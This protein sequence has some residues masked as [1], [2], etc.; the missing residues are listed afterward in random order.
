MSEFLSHSDKKDIIKRIIT[1]LHAGA[2]PEEIKDDFAKAIK[3]LTPEDIAKIEGELIKEGLSIEDVHKLCDAHLLVFR[4]SIE[5]DNIDVPSWHPVYILMKEHGIMLDNVGKIIDKIKLAKD[6]IGTKSFSSTIDEVKKMIKDS[7]KNEVH[8]HREENVLFA[9]L[10]KYGIAESP[11]IMWMDHDEV[12]DMKKKIYMLSEKIDIDN[13][14]MG[15]TVLQN[16]LVEL[17]EKIADH[18]Y[19]ENK[20][21]FPTALKV[22]SDKEWVLIR[23][24]FDEIGYCCFVPEEIPQEL[25]ILQRENEQTKGD[26]INLPSGKFSL[27]ELMLVF[28]NLPVDITFVDKNDKVK[29]FSETKERVF[30]RSRSIVGREVQKCHP[31]KSVH[32][33][34]KILKDFKSGK[35]D[36]ADFWLNFGGKVIYISYFAIRDE[37]KEYIGTLEVTQDITQI[38]KIEG[39]KRIYDDNE[40]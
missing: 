37:N 32:I 24:E 23:K 35:R 10:E 15:L 36:K 34:E 22:I 11:Q 13:P 26:E 25:Q 7:K 14:E 6:R 12:R 4:E 5:K 8:Y 21:L 17:L 9:V 27:K 33:V 40:Q 3:N 20:I 19:K 16:A 39:E 18:F 1:K 28:N 31:Q 30:V 38:Q 2:A 29:Y